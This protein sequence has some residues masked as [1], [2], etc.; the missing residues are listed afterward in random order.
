MRSRG[1]RCEIE[2]DRLITP[3][4]PDPSCAHAAARSTE[5]LADLPP[6]VGT[7]PAHMITYGTQAQTAVVTDAYCDEMVRH[8]SSETE[9]SRAELRVSIFI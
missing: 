9:Q 6:L 8:A 7:G 3:Y 5:T 1:D 4:A 2:G